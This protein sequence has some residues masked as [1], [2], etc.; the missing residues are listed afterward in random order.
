M[1]SRAI[2]GTRVDATTYGDAAARVLRWAARGESRSVCCANVHMVMEAHD[3]PAFRAV[4]ASSDLVTADGTPLAW[5]LRLLGVRRAPR[6][7]GP[8]LM[9]EVCSAAARE[10]IPAHLSGARPAR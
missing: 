5:A 4:L 8:R 6:V 7:Y 10:R 9:L 2:L 3:D 1:E